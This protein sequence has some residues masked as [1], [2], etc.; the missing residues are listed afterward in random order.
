MLK[1]MQLS[2]LWAFLSDL[3]KVDTGSDKCDF[4]TSQVPPGSCAG[5]L[6][7][8]LKMRLAAALPLTNTGCAIN[9]IPFRPDSSTTITKCGQCDPQQTLPSGYNPNCPIS[10]IC[11]DAG[12]C[13]R[14]NAYELFGQPCP[15]GGASL[16]CGS[17]I[18]INRRCAQCVDGTVIGGYTC[19]GG[20]YYGDY[21][22]KMRADA[23]TITA[24]CAIAVTCAVI[25]LC[26][27]VGCVQ[28]TILKRKIKQ[29][30]YQK[31]P[32]TN[33]NSATLLSTTP[34]TNAQS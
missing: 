6:E 9:Q 7:R 5:P 15:G 16:W 33:V 10:H 19:I 27:I 14:A 11:N 22:A 34:L 29:H 3:N 30:I 4:T 24:F 31:I 32:T 1:L 25:L 8:A 12:L 2:L 21:L 17:L 18:C 20:Q 13:T 26:S 28:C 23:S